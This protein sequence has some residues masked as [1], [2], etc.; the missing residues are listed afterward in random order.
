MKIKKILASFAVATI[1]VIGVPGWEAYGTQ[2]VAHAITSADLSV[3]ASVAYVGTTAT[4][5]INV[6]NLGPA[7]STDVAVSDPLPATLTF[8]STAFDV[9]AVGYNVASDT[10]TIGY[11]PSGGSQTITLTA[12]VAAGVGTTVANT[13]TVNSTSTSDPSLANN[14]ATASFT[15]APSADLAIAQ[16]V[17]HST[18]TQGSVI[19]YTITASALGPST[20]TGVTVADLLP[21]GLTFV[22]AT[23]SVGTYNATTGVWTIGDMTASSSA[24]LDIAATANAVGIFHNAAL[25]S[26]STSSNDPNLTNNLAWTNITVAKGTPAPIVAGLEVTKTVNATTAL[27]GAMVNYTITAS[28]LGPATSTGVTVS[29]PWP[30]GLTFVNAT[31]SAGTYIWTT[32]TW[33]LGN[34]AASSSATLDIAAMVNASD[35]A[36]TS[37]VNTATAN[38][39]SID[40]NPDAALASSSA[41]FM[42]GSSGGGGSTSTTSLAAPTNL[43]G[44]STQTTATLSWTAST[45][46]VAPITYTVLR[47]GTSTGNTTSTT[48]TDAGLTPSTTYSY[49]VKATD[50]ATPTPNAAVSSAISVTT[51]A[52]TSTPPAVILQSVSLGTNGRFT[53]RGMTVTSVGSSSFQATVWGIAYTIDVGPAATGTKVYGE[54]GDGGNRNSSAQLTLAK[55]AVGNA[56][57]VS[58]IVTVA[59]PFVVNATSVRIDTGKQTKNGDD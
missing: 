49:V 29:D 31:S 9:T 26:E 37:V 40:T 7:S 46:G 45:G 4:Y 17:D 51:L 55:L 33:S 8:E 14:T 23:T 32:G 2:A 11:L 56:V 38:E 30:A 41:V 59:S 16:S 13:V 5:T 1:A 36:G 50:S 15:V 42:V 24:T 53:G 35:T 43:L 6:K 3:A 44:T 12:D 48:F 19:H 47:N 28:A 20:S 27:P 25:G 22:S 58:G 34:L 10:W 18:T 52:A 54:D 21:A 39:S 57:D